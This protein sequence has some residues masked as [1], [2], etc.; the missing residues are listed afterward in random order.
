[1]RANDYPWQPLY[2]VE[3]SGQPEVVVFGIVAVVTADGGRLP[4]EQSD[5]DAPT[6]SAD[7]GGQEESTAASNA[8]RQEFAA[9]SDQDSPNALRQHSSG[10]L[11]IERGD[12]SYKLWTR[13]LLKPW[14]LSSHFRI[15]RE[16]YPSLTPQQFALMTSS[17]SAEKIHLDLLD[18]IM[19]I[20][21]ISADKLKC[22]PTLPMSNEMKEEIKKQ[23]KGPSSLYHNCSGKHCSYLLSLQAQGLPLDDYISLENPEHKRVDR[24]LAE[25]LGVSE[26]S[27]E[28][29]TDGCQLP[30]QNLSL[31]QMATLYKQIAQCAANTDT[32]AL[33]SLNGRDAKNDIGY[34][35]GLM[36][37][38]PEV[39]G[40]QGRLDTR[41]MA[42]T[43]AADK[44]RRFVAKGGADG[45]L[46]IGVLPD[47]SDKSAAGIIIKLAAGHDNKHMETITAEILRRLGIAVAQ[48]DLFTTRE[49]TDHLKTTFFLDIKSRHGACI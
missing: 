40:G 17:H 44:K 25:S 15:L 38:Y 5:V 34:I 41:I 28:R 13:S 49:R 18:Q 42:G 46:A 45:L 12:S 4:S 3:R 6:A 20:G 14:Q 27:F 7:A 21:K 9:A 29:T 43:F 33:P 1:M 37:L 47:E 35:G 22:P 19:C 11:L 26:N 31:Q 24:A 48:P 8:T 36:R 10:Q 39:I 32:R 23:G 16:S 30:N 2:M